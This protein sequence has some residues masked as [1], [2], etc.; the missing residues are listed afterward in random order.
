MFAISN[1][2]CY[3]NNTKKKNVNTYFK[4]ILENYFLLFMEYYVCGGII[5]ITVESES[6]ESDETQD[7]IISNVFNHYYFTHDA[8]VHGCLWN[9]IF[10][11]EECQRSVWAGKT[12][13]FSFD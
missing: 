9:R 1:D 12:G 6:G 13:Y 11:S 8:Y 5:E 10:Y 2:Y 7:K 3:Y 4:K